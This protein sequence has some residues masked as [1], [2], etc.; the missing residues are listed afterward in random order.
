MALPI[1]LVLILGVIGLAACSLVTI[2]AA[3]V[4]DVPGQ[5]GYY[6]DRQAIFFAVGGVISLG[7]SRL[8]YG[9]LRRARWWIYGFLMSS[10]LAVMAIGSVA[11]GAQRSIPVGP[12]QF[13]AS[14]LGKILLVVALAGVV[15]E[16]SRRLG[17]RDTTARIM[18]LALVPAALVMV[19]PDLGS[20]LVYGAIVLAVLYFAGTPAR[21]FLALFAL[22]AVAISFVL[23]VAPRAGVEV[24]HPY[25]KQRLTSF[26]HPSSDPADAGYQQNQ[27]LIAIGSG[28]KTGRGDR[29]TQ[30]KFNFLPEHHTDFINAVV[31]ERW[32]FVGAA[33]V[34]SLYALLIWRGLRILTMAKDLFGALVAG[35]I[36]AMLLFQVFVNVGMTLGIMPITGIPL[37]L[38]SYGGSSVMST[39][40]AIGLLQSIYVQG[41]SS[42]ALKGRIVSH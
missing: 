29:A 4:D 21:H 15:T 42:A 28:E 22:G 34:L 9:L 19:Q 23:V 12:F 37:P 7:L 38:M 8:D 30:T 1:D 27:S 11:K 6:F 2:R 35:G 20:S 16:R 33:L 3:T 26:L 41:R 13:Q 31:G 5:P 25:Q 32:G 10:I 17:E 36:V 14:E 39:L 18:L 40:L 24:L